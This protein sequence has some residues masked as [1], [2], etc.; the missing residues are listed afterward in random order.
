[1]FSE[2]YFLWHSKQTIQHI[3][4]TIAILT[5]MEVG[6]VMVWEQVWHVA[7][8]V[9][10]PIREFMVSRHQSLALYTTNLRHEVNFL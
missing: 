5:M 7:S 6:L 3:V 9:V 1:M 4:L 2:V 8:L 10:K